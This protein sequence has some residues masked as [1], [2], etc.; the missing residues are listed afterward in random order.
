ME[1][2]LKKVLLSVLILYGLLFV[3]FLNDYNGVFLFHADAHEYVALAKNIVEH[4]VFS[5]DLVVPEIIRTPGYPLLIAVTMAVAGD[6]FSYLV[7]LIQILMVGCTAYTIYRMAII[8]FDNPRLGT[9][10][11]IVYV[12]M[13]TTIYYAVTGMTETFFTFLLALT[14]YLLASKEISYRKAFLA[15]AI[16]GLA[17]LVRPIAILSPIII[18]PMA[19]RNQWRNGIYFLAGLILILAPWVIRNYQQ[20]Y[21]VTVSYIGAFNLAHGNAAKFYQWQNNVDAPVALKAIEKEVDTVTRDNSSLNTTQAHKKVAL[22]HILSNIPAYAWFH[23]VKTT[24]F[25]LASS[26]KGIALNLHLTN[27]GERTADLL[28][29]GK[30]AGI[31]LKLIKEFP[32]TMESILRIALTILMCI[33]L[34]QAWKNKNVFLVLLFLLIIQFG[35]LM[36]PWAE[37][38]FRVPLEP[39]VLLLAFSVFIKKMSLNSSDL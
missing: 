23:V 8:L 4:K 32:F 7:V 31:I 5:R 39:Y 24:P 9:L 3:S 30:S 15:G 34:W 28:L 6:Q 35:L 20:G 27:S 14:L 22:Q 19:M 18:L 21:G 1:I 2:T 12:L 37:V 36:S 25:F 26:I 38:R 16:I 11:A 29:K 10:V 17:I 13:P 33:G